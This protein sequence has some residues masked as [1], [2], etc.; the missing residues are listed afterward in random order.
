MGSDFLGGSLQL[1]IFSYSFIWHPCYIQRGKQ[2]S[3]TLSLQ[4]V[5]DLFGLVRVWLLLFVP[6]GQNQISLGRDKHSAKGIQTRKGLKCF[7]R[8]IGKWKKKVIV[9]KMNFIYLD[10]ILDFSW[11]V[12]I[13]FFFFKLSFHLWHLFCPCDLCLFLSSVN[14]SL[15]QWVCL[16]KIDELLVWSCKGAKMMQ[17]FCRKS[18]PWTVSWPRCKLIQVWAW[19]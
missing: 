8:S 11:L 18:L 10:V 17:R 5:Y 15:P 19:L 3:Q 2:T 16:L 4:K 9:N 1:W 14:F 13:L 6:A 12:P 7:V